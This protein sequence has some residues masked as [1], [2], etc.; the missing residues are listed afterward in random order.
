MYLVVGEKSGLVGV[1]PRDSRS[2]SRRPDAIAGRRR[3]SVGAS[4]GGD[5]DDQ[6]ALSEAR[7]QPLVDAVVLQQEKKQP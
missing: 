7:R 4:V 6:L 2:G 1:R 3:Q 5:S